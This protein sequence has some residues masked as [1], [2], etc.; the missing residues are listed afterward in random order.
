LKAKDSPQGAPAFDITPSAVL[1]DTSKL[2]KLT[3]NVQDQ[4]VCT[5]I[6]SAAIFDSIILPLAENNN[7]EPIAKP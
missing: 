1:G 5:V 2:L 3:H 7:K 4:I 6:A